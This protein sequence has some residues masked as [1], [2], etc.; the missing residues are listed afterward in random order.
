MSRTPGRSVFRIR[1]G[2]DS[3]FEP[4]AV[5]AHGEEVA[6]LLRVALQ[7]DAQRA[8]E[9]VDR[10]RRALVLGAPAAGEDVVAAERAAARLEEEPQHLEFLRGH[11][12]GRSVAGDRLRAQVRL[13][14]AELDAV[15]GR[16]VARRA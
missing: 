16:V 6:R 4:V 15:R 12:D 11:L 7:L 1:I 14:L 5:A 13:D 10:A 3:P 2:V 8:D 9:V